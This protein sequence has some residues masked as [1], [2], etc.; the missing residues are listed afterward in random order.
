MECD[1]NLIRNPLKV[2]EQRG[3]IL[4][5]IINF[6]DSQMKQTFNERMINFQSG[7]ILYYRCNELMPFA[8]GYAH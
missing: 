4:I 6:L 5:W 1:N 7:L 8:L 3:N 2:G